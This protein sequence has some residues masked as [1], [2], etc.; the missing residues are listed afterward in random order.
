[1]SPRP[2]RR[3]LALAALAAGFAAS[4][5]LAQQP[6]PRAVATLAEVEGSVLVSNPTGLG[7]GAK[8]APLRNGTRVITPA[9]ARAV[10]RFEDGCVVELKPNQRLVIDASVPCEGRLLMAQST[11]PQPAQVAA[12][13]GAASG[14]GFGGSV[15]TYAGY[16]GAAVFTLVGI[17]RWRRE[18]NGPGGDK[19]QPVSPN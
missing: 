7:A 13:N 15:Q 14:A 18:N 10:I 8:G 19:D 1:M 4:F 6:A 9:N 16:A 17:E 12:G 3:S 2:Y 5:A 11:L